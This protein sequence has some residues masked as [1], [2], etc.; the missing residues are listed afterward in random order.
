MRVDFRFIRG[1]HPRDVEVPLPAP[2]ILK[3]ILHRLF[4]NLLVLANMKQRWPIFDGGCL[5][6]LE[7]IFCQKR[8]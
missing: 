4:E 6:A 3:Q 1:H 2:H 7:A 5:T 8:K